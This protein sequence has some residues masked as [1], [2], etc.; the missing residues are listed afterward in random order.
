[1]SLLSLALIYPREPMKPQN[2]EVIVYLNKVLKNEPKV[3]NIRFHG[4][5]KLCRCHLESGDT[6][7]AKKQCTEA[8]EIRDDEARILCDRAE[9]YLAEDMFEEVSHISFIKVWK[10]KFYFLGCE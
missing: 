4:Y 8:L 2:P 1:M 9:A 7:E 6:S 10:F 5:D 3:E